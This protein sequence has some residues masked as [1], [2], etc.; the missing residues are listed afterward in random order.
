M[1]PLQVLVGLTAIKIEKVYDYTQVFFSDGTVLSVFN[2]YTF[3]RGSLS[4]IRGRKVTSVEDQVN[5]ISVFFENDGCLS[6][7]LS[8][9]GYNGPE[10][11]VLR[12]AG[13]PPVVWN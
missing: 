1:T 6:I 11:V 9:D 5:A 8:D 13:K 7:G 4:G 12:Q 10:A 3:E 2:K